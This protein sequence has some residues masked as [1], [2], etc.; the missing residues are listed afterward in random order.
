V[1]DASQYYEGPTQTNGLTSNDTQNPRWNC[2][3]PLVRDEEVAGSNPVTPTGVG[4]VCL[5]KA[6]THAVRRCVW[7]PSPQAPFAGGTLR[8]PPD[9]PG[10]ERRGLGF[11]FAVGVGFRWFGWVGL[12]FAFAVGCGRIGW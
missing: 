1:R 4:G 2:D 3:P 10:F 7:G 6:Q 9:P 12:G 5:R 8:I 11:A